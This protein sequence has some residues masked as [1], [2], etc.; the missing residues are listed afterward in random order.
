MTCW[1]EKDQ[2]GRDT[3]FTNSAEVGADVRKQ[4]LHAD[5]LYIR[6][7]DGRAFT[8]GKPISPLAPHDAEMAKHY[9]AERGMPKPV[10]FA[11][12][13]PDG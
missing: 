4:A 6:V 12:D 3:I 13:T 7:S 10:V 9:L 8:A 5:H 2:F 1:I 11:G